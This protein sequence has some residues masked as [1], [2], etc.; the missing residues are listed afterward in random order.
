[1]VVCMPDIFSDI[2]YLANVLLI[3]P[4]PTHVKAAT[5]TEDGR[6]RLQSPTAA[7]FGDATELAALKARVRQVTLFDPA[8][9]MPLVLFR[10]SLISSF[11]LR[12]CNSKNC[13]TASSRPWSE[14]R[15]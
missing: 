2:K 4:T 12:L 9:H 15:I 7:F 11:D 3:F 1:M 8:S 13:T 5:R 6:L 14:E 10:S